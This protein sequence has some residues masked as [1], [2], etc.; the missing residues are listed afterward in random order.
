VVTELAADPARVGAAV[1]FIH[2]GG[3]FGLF[4]PTDVADR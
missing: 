1:A 3:M 4:A 2:T